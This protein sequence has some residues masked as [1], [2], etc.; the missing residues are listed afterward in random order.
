MGKQTSHATAGKHED[1]DQKGH[2]E[3]TA[4]LYSITENQGN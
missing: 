3:E 2:L 1:N 4:E